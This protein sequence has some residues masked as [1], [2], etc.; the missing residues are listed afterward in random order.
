MSI[1]NFLKEKG[2]A[3]DRKQANIV[4]IGIIILC[5]ALMFFISRKSKPHTVSN[6][7]LTPEEIELMKLTETNVPQNTPSAHNT[8]IKRKNH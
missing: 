2:I 6:Q 5:L 8:S 3:R 7:K 1:E 4:M